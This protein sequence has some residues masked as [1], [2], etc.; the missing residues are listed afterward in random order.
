MKSVK[1]N[2]ENPLPLG[3][4]V[5][6]VA[7]VVIFG[8]I[9]PFVDMITDLRMIS[10]LY[11]GIEKPVYNES[12]LDLIFWINCTAKFS[13]TRCYSSFTFCQYNPEECWT[14]QE[15]HPKFATMLLGKVK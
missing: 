10:R 13:L 11:I 9:L 1:A 4:L 15:Q 7:P 2:R 3:Q 8:V 6:M 12:S 14:D 5:K